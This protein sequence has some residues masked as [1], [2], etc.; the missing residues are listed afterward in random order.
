MAADRAD[1]PVPQRH[2]RVDAEFPERRKKR[3]RPH[4]AGWAAT[5]HHGLAFQRGIEEFFTDT[6][7]ASMSMWKYVFIFCQP[8]T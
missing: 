4:P 7:N 2:G 8:G 3:P 6:K 5:H 1:R